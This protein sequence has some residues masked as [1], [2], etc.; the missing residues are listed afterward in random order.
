MAYSLN[1]NSLD[2]TNAFYG[3]ITDTIYSLPVICC[4]ARMCLKTIEEDEGVA[5][6]ETG[7]LPNSNVNSENGRQGRFSTSLST[8]EPLNQLFLILTISI[9]IEKLQNE[10][11][12]LPI[13]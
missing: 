10:E 5:E 2:Y 12:L 1:K 4:G 8:K 13:T 9:L 7:V 6:R 3:T 11:F